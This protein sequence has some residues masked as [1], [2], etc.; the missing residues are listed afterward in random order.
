M[1]VTERIQT[2]ESRGL[3]GQAHRHVQVQE[4]VSGS[5]GPS[6]R[7]QD[8]VPGCPGTA[9][10]ARGGADRTEALKAKSLKEIR[11]ELAYVPSP[12]RQEAVNFTVSIS[13]SK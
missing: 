3:S 11:L 7:G 10:E 5:D 9:H 8:P 12:Y 13:Q 6:P 2:L 4:H 1:K